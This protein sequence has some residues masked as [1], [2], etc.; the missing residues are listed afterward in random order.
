LLANVLPSHETVHRFLSALDSGSAD[1]LKAAVNADIKFIFAGKSGTARMSETVWGFHTTYDICPIVLITMLSEQSEDHGQFKFQMDEDLEWDDQLKLII[2]APLVVQLSQLCALLQAGLLPYS[3][4]SEFGESERQ[5]ACT[6]P[7]MWLVLEEPQR[8][9]RPVSI[10]MHD[11]RDKFFGMYSSGHP[12]LTQTDEEEASCDSR[13]ADLLRLAIT[14]C[15][16]CTGSDNQPRVLSR[17]RD[18]TIQQTKKRK[19]RRTG[20]T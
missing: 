14:L 3:M 18:P 1:A 11:C 12:L 8:H 15:C 19:R 9:N 20:L 16:D 13:A 7:L 10:F 2:R 4:A 17:A 6:N 5:A